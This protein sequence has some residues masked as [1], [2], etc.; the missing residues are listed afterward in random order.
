LVAFGIV[1]VPKIAWA[2]R[3]TES[4]IAHLYGRLLQAEERK[5][6]ALRVMRDCFVVVEAL[7]EKLEANEFVN[8]ESL[9]KLQGWLDQIATLLVVSDHFEEVERGSRENVFSKL[10]SKHKLTKKVFAEVHAVV[11][12]AHN[13]IK[14][15]TSRVDFMMKLLAKRD[16]YFKGYFE[17][18]DMIDFL[19]DYP[20]DKVLPSQREKLLS[21][22]LTWLAINSSIGAVF[23]LISELTM[24]FAPNYCPLV[25]ILKLYHSKFS[26]FA[27]L[28]FLFIDSIK[29][30][31]LL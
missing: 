3:T 29:T 9:P 2:Y 11:L 10:M 5:Q 20:V 28:K 13:R 6:L 26:I 21:L 16:P 17:S 14:R 23:I 18:E 19:Q 30:V 4:V 22:G 27:S 7:H 1:L 15:Y 8:T 25:L 12:Q 24:V 31:C